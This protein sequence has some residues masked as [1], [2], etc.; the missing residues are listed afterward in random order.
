M[1]LNALKYRTVMDEIP[2]SV[3]SGLRILNCL[4]GQGLNQYRSPIHRASDLIDHIVNRVT[5]PHD[6]AVVNVLSDEEYL[7][8]NGLQ[9]RIM[10]AAMLVQGLKLR[11]G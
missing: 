10:L 1:P 6:S 8:N 11:R 3:G 9:K 5:V 7:V 4:H 2:V